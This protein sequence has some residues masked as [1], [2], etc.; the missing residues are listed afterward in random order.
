MSRLPFLLRA[1]IL[2]AGISPAIAL[3]AID[4]DISGHDI[5]GVL[6]IARG[7][8]PERAAF[9]APYLLTAADPTVERLEVITERR[10]VALLAQE[11]IAL[12][13][14]MFTRGTLSAEQALRAWRRKV[15]IMVRFAFPPQNSYI[16]APPLDIA[17]VDPD[18][19]RV[20]MKGDTLFAMS[21]GVAGQSLP[22]IGAAGEALYDAVAIGQIT[23]TVVVRL[24]GRE[25]ARQQVDFGQLR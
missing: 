14:F 24:G 15:T 23:H 18:V 4:L 16:L 3:H 20:D 2:A 13:D 22:V 12:G 6:A 17:L 8:E 19:P 9:H 7:P 1:C 10:R 25:V 21:T 11:R 5:E